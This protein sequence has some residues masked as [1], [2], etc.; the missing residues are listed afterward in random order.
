MIAENMGGIIC[1]SH[2]GDLGVNEKLDKDTSDELRVAF[3]MNLRE[4]HSALLVK[5][6]AFQIEKRDWIITLI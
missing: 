6:I 4:M 2:R 5:K 1:V 3:K